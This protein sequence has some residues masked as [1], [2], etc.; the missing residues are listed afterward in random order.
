MCFRNIKESQSLLR[1]AAGYLYNYVYHLNNTRIIPGLIEKP[2][3]KPEVREAM[4]NI[5]NICK[6]NV[7]Y[8]ALRSLMSYLK[9]DA[10]QN[11]PVNCDVIYITSNGNRLR[12]GQGN[13][14]TDHPPCWR[15]MIY[16]KIGV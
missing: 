16:N 7:C 12:G 15:D 1:E 4:R 13:Q 8:E 2:L 9:L 11:T 10:I 14:Y 5:S 3:D 6:G